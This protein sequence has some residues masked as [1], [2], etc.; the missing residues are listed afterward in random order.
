M[1]TL[2]SISHMALSCMHRVCLGSEHTHSLSLDH[3]HRSRALSP[4]HLTTHSFSA[5]PAGVSSVGL[6]MRSSRVW[7]LRK[8]DRGDSAAF[9]DLVLLPPCPCPSPCADPTLSELL[10]ACSGR[11]ELLVRWT[12]PEAEPGRAHGCEAA[13]APGCCC[14]CTETWGLEPC[15]LM[16]GPCPCCCCCCR[17]TKLG[18]SSCRRGT[19]PCGPAAD[20]GHGS[21]AAACWLSLVVREDT[22]G[23]LPPTCTPAPA[24]GHGTG[25]GGTICPA[26]PSS[27]VALP[28]PAPME[29]VDATETPWAMS[30]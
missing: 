5:A 19:S 24:P 29:H 23:G 28:A 4:T 21:P 11:A 18:G 3:T 10:C 1:L 16:A 15:L 12:A 6:A 25:V 27:P 30:S 13:P 9:P 7:M 2:L 26:T 17:G 22:W 8:R 14:A 20:L